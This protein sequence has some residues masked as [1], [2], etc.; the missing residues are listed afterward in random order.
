MID[1]KFQGRLTKMMQSKRRG[2][3]G[4]LE[5][6]RRELRSHNGEFSA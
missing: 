4:A 5:K 3:L 2:V 6:R 1:Y